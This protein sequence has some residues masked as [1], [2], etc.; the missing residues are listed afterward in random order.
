MVSSKSDSGD[1]LCVFANELNISNTNADS[2][3]V[4]IGMELRIDLF[5]L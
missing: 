3:M 5:L 4:F 2:F 1:F